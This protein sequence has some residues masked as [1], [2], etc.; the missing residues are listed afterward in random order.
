MK[1]FQTISELRTYLAAGRKRGSKVSFVPTM[2]ALHAGHKAC[3]DIARREGGI[4]VS[5]IFVNPTQFGPAEDFDAYP[6]P[7]EEDTA[8]LLQWGCDAVFLPSV[9]EMY[10]REQRV[11]VEAGCLADVLCGKHRA[12]HFRGVA[13]VVAKLFHIV[14]PHVAVFGQKD[15]QQ[16]IIIREMARQLN[17]PVAILLC[18]TVREPD[19]LAVSSR[20]RYLSKEDR[21]AAAGLY[22]GLRHGKALL[23]S[24][25]REARAITESVRRYLTGAGILGTEYVELLN[26][27]D[28]SPTDPVAGRVLL[29]A[30]ARIG[31]TRLI[32]NIVLEVRDGVRET[33]LF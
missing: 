9:R 22:A 8:G 16:A 32:D 5:S 25:E 24:G 28:L 31:S 18:P 4:L 2:G 27:E 33:M 10:E 30:A 17:M 12:G 21:A 1:S 6:R 3:I 15:A 19:G 14:E 7:V 20:N 11:W 29:A 23:E 13:T 26:A